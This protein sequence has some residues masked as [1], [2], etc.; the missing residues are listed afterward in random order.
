MDPSHKVK[1]VK[2]TSKALGWDVLSHP[3]YSPDLAPSDYQFFALMANAL[4]KQH[5]AYFEEI[6]KWFDEWF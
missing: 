4:A 1:P 2:K 6:R 5:L 3:L